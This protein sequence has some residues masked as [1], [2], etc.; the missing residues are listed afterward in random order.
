ME[1][2]AEK[3]ERIEISKTG[4]SFEGRP[5]ILLTITSKKNHDRIEE[6]RTNHLNLNSSNEIQNDFKNMP[7]VIYQ[8]YSIHGN[9]PSGSNAAMLYA[10]Y[11]AANNNPTHLKTLDNVVILLDPAM[12]PDGLQRFA[13]W[14]NT[15]KSEYLNPD[16]YDREFNENWPRGRTNH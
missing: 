13:N 11:L 1:I 10:Y 14:V 9:E 4:E 15:N 6:I 5:L 16:S 3:S 12:N 8:G 2:L 7:V